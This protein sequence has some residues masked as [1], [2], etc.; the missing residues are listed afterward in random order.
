MRTDHCLRG[1]SGTRLLLGGLAWIAVAPGPAAAALNLLVYNNTDLV[2]VAPGD[3]TCDADPSEGGITCT[4]RAAVME[5]NAFPGADVIRVNPG[6]YDLLLAE[7]GSASGGDLDITDPVTIQNATATPPILDGQENFPIFVGGPGESL[8]LRGLT[9]RN[10]FSPVGGCVRTLGDLTLERVEMYFCFSENGGGAVATT[11]GDLTV[12]DSYFHGNTADPTA[13]ETNGRGGAILFVGGAGLLARLERVTLDSNLAACGGGLALDGESVLVNVTIIGNQATVCG[14]GIRA[15]DSGRMSNSTVVANWC[16]GD[17]F[18]GGGIFSFDADAWR[19]ENSVIAQNLCQDPPVAHDCDGSFLSGGYNF[20][21]IG[22][23]CS[24]FNGVGDVV[25][26]GPGS[27]DP[28]VLPSARNGGWAPTRL[29]G[30]GS[31]LLDAGDPDGC[32]VD[33][34]GSGPGVETIL[35]NDQR[36]A[37]RPAGGR[38]ERGAVELGPFFLDSFES[39]STARWSATAA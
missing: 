36:L 1:R 33:R 11:A 23:D 15:T 25:G 16:E 21:G 5:T 35:A 34:D 39:G 20:I 10:G 27:L 28:V 29:P 24:G 19:I 31:P 3:G 18:Q 22:T 4:L 13:G 37:A 7:T 6:I 14:G 26:G 30:P 38:C 8:T 12:V 9:L 2:D 17:G 32:V